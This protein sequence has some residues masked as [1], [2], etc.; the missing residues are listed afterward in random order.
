MPLKFSNALLLLL[1]IVIVRPAF[2]VSPPVIVAVEPTTSVISVSSVTPFSVALMNVGIARP[3]PATREIVAFDMFA[4]VFRFAV[5][6]PPMVSVP[7]PRLTCELMLVTP[8]APGLSVRF[9]TSPPPTLSVMLPAIVMLFVALSVRLFVTRVLMLRFAPDC[10]V[11]FP[12]PA[13]LALEVL[14]VTLPLPN[15]PVSAVIVISEVLTA[16][17]SWNT[18]PV[19]SVSGV[20]V[21]VA[22]MLTSVGSSS[23]VPFA[24]LVARVSTMPLKS[25]QPLPETSTVP[26]SPDCAPPRAE[27]LP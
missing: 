7:P 20:A 6:V 24:P 16:A 23:R 15:A 9:N 11:M 22:T 4:P 25:S 14:M 1:F 10:Q 2:S 8:A 3:A 5:P 18:W 13:P 21:L 19:R 27:T 26:P 17:V 12:V